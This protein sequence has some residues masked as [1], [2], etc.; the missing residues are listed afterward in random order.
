VH[1]ETCGAIGGIHSTL[2]RQILPSDPLPNC[3]LEIL[4]MAHALPIGL[5][6]KISHVSGV[7]NDLRKLDT[8]TDTSLP[9]QS[10]GLK[11][12]IKPKAMQY[13]AP[14]KFTDKHEE[15][16]Y[17]KGRL[18]L[19]C[20]IFGKLGF[21]EGVAGH[22]TLRDPINPHHFWGKY[23]LHRTVHVPSSACALCQHMY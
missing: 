23:F 8:G 14:P 16:E 11:Q 22:I 20:R 9:S 21:E 4:E 15:R 1:I 18:A 13:P 3:K 12:N 10:D 5:G 7:S 17:R 2:F 19:A 6:D